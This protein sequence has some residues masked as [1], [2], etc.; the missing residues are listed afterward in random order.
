M[1][2]HY[3]FKLVIEPCEEGGYFGRCPALDGCFVQG[4]TLEETRSELKAAVDG[5]VEDM[6]ERGEKVP[7][8]D[9]VFEEYEA[10]IR[11]PIS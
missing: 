2:R 10:I 9:T 5:F 7:E 8:D 11:L 6:L 4:E 1:E 3:R